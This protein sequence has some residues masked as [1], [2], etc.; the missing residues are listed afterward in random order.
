MNEQHEV[1][2]PRYTA[3]ASL[4]PELLAKLKARAASERR[5]VSNMITVILEQGLDEDRREFGEAA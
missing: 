5:T 3:H 4:A 2:A 1:K